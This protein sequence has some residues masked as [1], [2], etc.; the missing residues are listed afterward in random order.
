MDNVH[1]EKTQTKT[2]E[3]TQNTITLKFSNDV[4]IEYNV[5]T[6]LLKNSKVIQDCIY[7]LGNDNSIYPI[8][9]Q[10]TFD[11]NELDNYFK[12]VEYSFNNILY[13]DTKI[14]ELLNELSANCV[15]KFI[16]L[17][18]YLD[19]TNTLDTLCTYFANHRLLE[20]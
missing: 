6:Y 11:K 16:L 20:L 14:P 19:D 15:K 18:D 1:E 7:A 2:Q 8:Y 3:Q 13:Q 9:F 17:A 12:T 5:F 10:Y 4:P